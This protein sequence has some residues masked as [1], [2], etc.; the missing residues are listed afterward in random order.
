MLPLTPVKLYFANDHDLSFLL[1]LAKAVTPKPTAHIN[2][3]QKILYLIFQIINR[4]SQ[5]KN[6][7]ILFRLKYFEKKC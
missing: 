7:L 5:T 4:L 1:A 2:S 6:R 3:E